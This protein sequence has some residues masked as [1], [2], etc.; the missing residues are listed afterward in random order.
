MTSAPRSATSCLR[1][2]T[3]RLSCPR[4]EQTMSLPEKILLRREAVEDSP[5]CVSFIGSFRT[6][7]CRLVGNG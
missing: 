4:W 1:F 2:V 7:G 3:A 5:D 6:A